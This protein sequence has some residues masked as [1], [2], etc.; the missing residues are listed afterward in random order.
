MMIRSLTTSVVLALFAIT[1]MGQERTTATGLEL[2]RFGTEKDMPVFYQQLKQQLTFPWSWENKKASMSFADW[3][4]EARAEV[5]KTMQMAPPAPSSY[6]YEVL[7][8]EKRDGYVAQRISFSINAWEKVPALLL[9]PNMKKNQ[10]APAVLLLHDHGAH[11]QIGKEKMIRPVKPTEG[12]NVDGIT[13]ASSQYGDAK[14]TNKPEDNKAS[15]KQGDTGVPLQYDACLQD[16]MEWSKKC[17]DDRFVGDELA[18]AGYVVL[19]VDALFW[20]ERGRKEGVRY[21]SQQAL[22]ANMLQMGASWGAWIVWDDIRS[23]EFLSTLPMVDKDNIGCLGFSMGAHRAWMLSALSDNIKAG[24][25]VCWIND[26]EHLMSL[27]NNQN[28]GG[29]AYS[30][31]IPGIRNLMDYADVASLAC[32]KPMLFFN[33][34]KDKLFP[35]EGVRSAYT[36]LHNVWTS[37]NASNALTTKIWN[38][39]HFFNASMQTEVQS[40]FDT[41][42]KKYKK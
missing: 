16:A 1:A 33:G 31:I 26:T 41:N 34:E 29:S 37:Q 12:T 40:F 9:V 27:A 2:E 14:A 36:T 15:H 28:K 18:K 20:G 32:P 42:L 17:Y 3:R 10:K 4:R 13:G 38:E 24:A 19:A 23:A 6:D 7:A 25:A 39:K 11:F 30:M 5:M 22:A 35:V 21:D 8:K